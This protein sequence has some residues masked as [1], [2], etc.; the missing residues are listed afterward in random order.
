MEVHTQK[1]L[2]AFGI[3]ELIERVM[4][5]ES[6][7][8]TLERKFTSR[9]HIESLYSAIVE[10][11]CECGDESDEEVNNLVTLDLVKNVLAAAADGLWKE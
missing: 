2:E 6:Q 10:M 7:V 4:E 9:R 5:I 1:E 11:R 8:A 3:S